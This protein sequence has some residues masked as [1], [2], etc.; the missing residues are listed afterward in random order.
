MGFDDAV[1]ISTIEILG[2][3]RTKTCYALEN[4]L[5]T[6]EDGSEKDVMKMRDFETMI[7]RQFLSSCQ[8]SEVSVLNA[9]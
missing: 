6:L 4:G 1:A 8:Q 2:H 3:E 5:I 9:E 7:L